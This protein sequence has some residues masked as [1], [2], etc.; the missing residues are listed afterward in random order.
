MQLTPFNKVAFGVDTLVGVAQEPAV[1]VAVVAA[2]MPSAPTAVQSPTAVQLT[3]LNPASLHQPA[4]P[5]SVIGPQ[6]PAD[7]VE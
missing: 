6:V 7:S 1:S 3:A 4:V 2:I 5:S